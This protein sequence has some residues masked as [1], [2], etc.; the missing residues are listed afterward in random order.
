[1]ADDTRDT[2]TAD[3][4]ILKE[5]RRKWDYSQTEWEDIRKEGKKNMLCAAGKVWEAMDPAGVKQRNDTGR[6]CLSLDELS[7]YVNQLV[8]DVRQNKRAIKVTPM[9]EGA[10]DDTAQLKEALIRQIEYRS[11]AQQAYTTGFEN[12]VQRGYG[13]WRVVPRYVS[14]NSDDQELIIEPIVNP[15]MC[16]PDPDHLRADGSDMRYFWIRESRTK[17][18]FNRQYPNAKHKDFGGFLGTDSSFK[19]WVSE[20]R[21]YIA[22]YWTLETKT[23]TLLTLNTI[24]GPKQYFEDELQAKPSKASILKSRK[25]ETTSVMK[26][27]TNGVEILERT[28]WPGKWLPFICCYGKVIYLD[29]GDGAKKTILSMISLARDPAQ[30]Y[31][32]YRTAEAEVVGMTPKTPYWAYEG[33]ISPEQ[34]VQIQ[35]SL[36]EPVALLKA[37]ATTEATGQQ[38]LGLP[39][40]QMYEPAIQ[41]LEVGAEAARRAIQ[42][43]IGSSPLPTQAQRRNEKSGVAL[44]QIEETAQ[45]GSFHF[46]DHYEDAITRTGAILDDLLPHFYDTARDVAIR[47]PDDSAEVVRINDPTQPDTETGKPRMVEAGPY[48]VTLSTGPSYDSERELA[49][50]FADT[51]VQTPLVAQVAGPAAAAKV[52]ALAIKLKNLGPLGQEMADTISPPQDEQQQQ[53]PPQVLAKL[54]EQEQMLAKAKQMIETDAAKQQA[55]IQ[56]AQIDAQADQAKNQID[57]QTKLRIAEIEAETKI[58]VEQMK[59]GQ[60]GVEARLK[61]LEE[62]M[63]HKADFIMQEREQAHQRGMAQVQHEHAVDEGERGL[64]RDLVKGEQSGQQAER[65]IEKQAEVSPPEA[66]A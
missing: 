11:N 1:M 58:A 39:Q 56:K 42:A 62:I 44:K 64:E 3:E 8:N 41:A 43:A 57:N 17:D 63:G 15:D 16:T 31:N 33:Q 13:F 45:K 46:I 40:R 19:A 5:M 27:V 38:V 34:E 24:E 12:C 28:P 22:E 20:D 32:Y 50:E 49:S 60:D 25:V 4:A 66:S 65:Q 54:Q 47:N 29:T 7:Q 14:D 51:L 6:P 55:T 48:D 2:D 21:C 36:H 37:K 61:H 35:K 53:I 23:R 9:G 30:L 10:N 18:E 52:L 59:L 26:Y